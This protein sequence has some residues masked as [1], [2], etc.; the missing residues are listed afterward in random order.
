MEAASK[1]EPW[2]GLCVWAQGDGQGET[3]RGQWAGGKGLQRGSWRCLLCWRV[4]HQALHLGLGKG[5]N[6]FGHHRSNAIQGT[7]VRGIYKEPVAKTA[8]RLGYRKE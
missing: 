5:T 2:A 3:G 4:V 7:M 6:H 8:S 1:L